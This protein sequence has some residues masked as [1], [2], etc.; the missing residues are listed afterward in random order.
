MKTL[1]LLPLFFLSSGCA[2]L[3]AH[4]TV[5][6]DPSFTVEEKEAAFV[7][8]DGW[9][10]AVPV[11]FIVVIG[12]CAGRHAQAICI[13]SSDAVTVSHAMGGGTE[14]LGAT[15]GPDWTL[16]GAEIFISTAFM[17]QIQSDQGAW[18]TEEVFAHEIGHGMGL[19]HENGVGA[20]MDKSAPDSSHGAVTAADA[21]QWLLLRN[22]ER[23]IAENGMP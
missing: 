22:Q 2:G 16:D 5:T 19:V 4:Y 12:S 7:A 21:E 11:T 3:G 17:L 6:L 18:V 13:H 1:F 20:L 15:A 10:H 8:L 14:F 9:S 23:P